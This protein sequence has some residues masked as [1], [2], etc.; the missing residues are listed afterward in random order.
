LDLTILRVDAAACAGALIEEPVEFDQDL[1]GKQDFLSG[2]SARSVVVIAGPAGFS[3][4]PTLRV[5]IRRS[6]EGEVKQIS[7]VARM[8]KPK[9]YE[10]ADLYFV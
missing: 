2:S 6:W 10:G 4:S 8:T 9:K 5:E 7:C 3:T 1:E